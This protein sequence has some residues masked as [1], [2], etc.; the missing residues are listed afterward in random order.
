MVLLQAVVHM[1]LL[2]AG[3]ARQLPQLGSHP[4]WKQPY[5]S[6]EKCSFLLA[7]LQAFNKNYAYFWQKKKKEK[8]KEKNKTRRG[9]GKNK[10]E[11]KFHHFVDSF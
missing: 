10:E 2:P 6:R 3:L 7:S 1:F 5:P 9:R 11:E 8:K 4:D